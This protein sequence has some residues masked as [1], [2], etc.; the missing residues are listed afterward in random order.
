VRPAHPGRNQALIAVLLLLAPT[1]ALAEPAGLIIDFQRS[2]LMKDLLAKTIAVAKGFVL[3]STFI[4]YA[5]EAFGKSPTLERDYA[6]V[7]W[8]VVVVLFLL[9]NYQPIFGSVIGLMDRL[10]KE[11]APESMWDR[12]KVEIASMRRSLD[13]LAEH[14][15][16]PAEGAG[17]ATGVS[18]A[19]AIPAPSGFTAWVYE[20][21]V[22]CL[23]LIGEGV[24]F[25]I[26]WL[27]R[28]LTATLFILGPLAL[29]AGIPRM[30]GTGT[31]WFQRFVTIASWPVFAG[32]LLSVLVTISAQG[33]ARHSYLE[34]LVGALVMLVTALATPTLASH[35]VGGALQN[36]AGIGFANVRA[37]R[38]D[39]AAP[40][41]RTAA[42]VAA[43]IKSGVT[44]AVAA[45]ATRG[46]SE[47]SGGPRGS[48]GGPSGG[49]GVTANPPA[50]PP[51][52]ARRGGGSRSRAAEGSAAPGPTGATPA[53]GVVAGGSVVANPP[54]P[55]PS[56]AGGRR[57]RDRTKGPE[58]A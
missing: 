24:V 44:S 17:G 39:L 33:A 48:G 11:V 32:V 29:V 8:R 21:L 55:S 42:T 23:Q 46:S 58:R 38:R 30:S 57:G 19:V 9:W 3:L 22:A 53:A 45:V 1:L 52:G 28:I 5:L 54:A 4:A 26:R 20:A 35:V 13:D 49:G 27:S 43:G 56:P 6:A 36:F 51:Q 31:R 40:L 41:G 34:C 15:E 10:E 12:F 2:G 14:G 47:G 16:R 25:L 7:T 37:A 50:G 18:T